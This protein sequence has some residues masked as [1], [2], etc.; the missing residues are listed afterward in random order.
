MRRHIKSC[1]EKN[2]SQQ[3]KTEAKEKLYYYYLMVEDHIKVITGYI[4]R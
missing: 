2:Y 3:A 4:C 1:I